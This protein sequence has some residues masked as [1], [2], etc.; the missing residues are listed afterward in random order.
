MPHRVDGGDKVQVSQCHIKGSLT[1]SKRKI[2][3]CMLVLLLLGGCAKTPSPFL[4]EFA[5]IDLLIENGQV[6]DGLGGV[7]NLPI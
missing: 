4:A 7:R 1:V 6:L 3:A 2:M 5:S